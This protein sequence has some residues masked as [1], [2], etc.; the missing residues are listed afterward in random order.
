MY[1]FERMMKQPPILK[2]FTNIQATEPLC[3]G[4]NFDAFLIKPVQRIP[5]Y[6]LF[7][8]RLVK[9]TPENDIDF[10]KLPLAL[11]KCD[12]IANIINQAKEKQI[13]QENMSKT[14]ARLDCGTELLMVPGRSFVKDSQIDKITRKSKKQPRCLFL[15]TDVLMVATPTIKEKHTVQVKFQLKGSEVKDLPDDTEKGFSNLFQFLSYPKSLELSA[16]S[17]EEKAEWIR[18]LQFHIQE[19]NKSIGGEKIKIIPIFEPDSKVKKCPLCDEKFTAIF[20]RHHC[21]QCRRVVCGNCTK[22]KR[23]LPSQSSGERKKRVCD[24][25]WKHDENWTP[26]GISHSQNPLSP[27]DNSSSDEDS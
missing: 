27:R 20:R 19:A 6:K 4:L 7:I 25:C 23:K 21:R 5:R 22:H 14:A 12:Q 15:F 13:Q 16:S 8:D 26:E 1:T 24:D 10:P 2:W 11:E 17:K 18:L 3:K 9:C